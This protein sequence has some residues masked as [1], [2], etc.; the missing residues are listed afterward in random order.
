MADDKIRLELVSPEK[1]L[2]AEDVSMA[3]L[4]GSEGQFGVLAGHIPLVSTLE[5]GAIDIY[6]GNRI[7]Q[8]IFVTGGF[9]EVDGERCVVLAEAATPLNEIDADTARQECRNL[10]EDVTDA[11]TDAA[12]LLASGK[13]AIAEAKLRVVTGDAVAQY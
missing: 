9:V 1:L 6:Q 10:K 4:P 8:R 3:V 13:L 12:R 5:P 2:L 11:K 7:E